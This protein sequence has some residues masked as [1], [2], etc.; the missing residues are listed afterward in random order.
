MLGKH[1]AAIVGLNVVLAW[2]AAPVR[3]TKLSI[4]HSRWC[5]NSR[6]DSLQDGRSRFLCRDYSSGENVDLLNGSRTV[7]FL[8]DELLS[9][10]TRMT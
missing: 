6:E 10:Q 1:A 9:D 7:L 5:V 4:S 2:L 3:A 8:M